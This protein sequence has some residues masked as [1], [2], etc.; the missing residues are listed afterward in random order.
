MT[1]LNVQRLCPSFIQ[2]NAN[3]SCLIGLLEKISDQTASWKSTG[4]TVM[5]TL[6]FVDVFFLQK[7]WKSC[8]EL[9][10]YADIWY[11]AVLGKNLLEG[12]RD[13]KFTFQQKK[14]PKH[15]IK[16]YSCVRTQG[17]TLN[18]LRIC[19]NTSKWLLTDIFHPIQLRLSFF[20]KKNGQKCYSPDL[21]N[22]QS[23]TPKDL[24]TRRVCS[25]RWR[26]RSCSHWHFC[27]R[28]SYCL[29]LF[30]FPLTLTRFPVELII[31]T[32]P[33]LCFLHVPWS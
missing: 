8:T 30:I 4:N 16:A 1:Y 6:G 21:Q 10:G 23:Y 27:S 28:T 22:W 24:Q 25:E 11:R 2:S 29:T 17:N 3:N 20:A 7:G 9:M 15:I 13:L 12:M 5:A 14:K 32:L 31:L 18:Q 26:L 19:I 33:T